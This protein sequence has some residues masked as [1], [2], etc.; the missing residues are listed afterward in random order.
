MAGEGEV[1]QISLCVFLLNG[2]GSLGLISAGSIETKLRLHLPKLGIPFQ[3]WAGA[4]TD[5][6]GKKRKER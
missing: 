4:V 5:A 6:D 2:L 1:V 3:M